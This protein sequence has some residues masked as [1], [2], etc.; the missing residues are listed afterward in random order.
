MR[1]GADLLVGLGMGRLGAAPRKLIAPRPIA[2]SDSGTLA[3]AVETT[4]KSLKGGPLRR[5]W[6]QPGAEQIRK[7]V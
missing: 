1:A 5:D 3:T 7:H 4:V 2:V 6:R